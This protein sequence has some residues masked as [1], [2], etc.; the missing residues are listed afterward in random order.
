MGDFRTRQTKSTLIEP[1]TVIMVALTPRN[2][3]AKA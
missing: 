3:V 1:K 2:S